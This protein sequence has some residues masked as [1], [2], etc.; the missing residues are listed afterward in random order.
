MSAR[1]EALDAARIEASHSSG[2]YAKRG[3][4]IVRGSGARLIDDAGREYVDC[5]SGHGVAALGHAHPE[6]TAAIGEQARTLVTCPESYPND[7]R[8]AYLAR[9]VPLLPGDIG[10]VFLCNSGAEA[11]E[12]VLKFARLS[13]GKSRVVATRRGFHG[14]TFG[15][16]SATANEKYRAPFEP[17]VPGFE[18]VPFDDVPAADAAIDERTACVLVEVIQGEGGVHVGRPEYFQALRR[19]CDERGALLA[20]DE[21]QTGFGRT[22][23]MFACEHADVVPDLIALGKAIGGGVPMGAVGI[24]PR[25]AALPRGSH[26]STFGGNPLACAAAIVVLDVIERD[27]LV[28]RAA[29]LGAWLLDRLR[30]LDASLVR[31]VRG[32]GLMAAVELRRRSTPYLEALLAEGVLALPAGPTGIRLLPPLNIPRDDLELAIDALARV[33]RRDAERGS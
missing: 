26:G 28:E 4:V 13:T 27:G 9:L 22:G 21:V 1:V 10:R 11:V 23:R 6:V 18:H 16:L 29:S 31:E 20:I 14:R 2:V 24:G 25:V 8:A 17:L 30:S 19:L 15:A 7:R 12:A 32:L 33:L 3:V 5:A